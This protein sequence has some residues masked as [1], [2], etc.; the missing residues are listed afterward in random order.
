MIRF[1]NVSEGK[2][3]DELRADGYNVIGG[4]ELGDR[5]EGDR[6]Y[7]QEVLRE[8]HVDTIPTHE[9]DDFDSALRFVREAPRRYVL[10]LN[11]TGWQLNTTYLGEMESGADMLAVL[12]VTRKRWPCDHDVSFV[13]MDRV[14]GVEVGVGSFFNGREFLR[15]HLDGWRR[16]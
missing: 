2:T 14:S 12:D 16:S 13:L 3:Q 9:F 8:I 6:A 5:L 1:E 11:S 10:K 4:S 7:G 15:Q